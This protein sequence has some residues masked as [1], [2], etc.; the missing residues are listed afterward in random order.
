M[1]VAGASRQKKGRDEASKKIVIKRGSLPADFSEPVKASED[2][3][4][5]RKNSDH[6]LVGKRS[7]RNHCGQRA[8]E[9]SERRERARSNFRRRESGR[10]GFVGEKDSNERLGKDGVCYVGPAKP[11]GLVNKVAKVLAR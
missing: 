8:V 9:G 7:G 5:G 11:C 3:F 1:V 10:N 6:R 2:V 4:F